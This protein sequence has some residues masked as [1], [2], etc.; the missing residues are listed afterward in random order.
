MS[1]VLIGKGSLAGKGVYACKGF[2]KGEVVIKYNFK[3][4]SEQE[5]KQL[6][7]S[8]KMFAHSHWGQIYLYGAPER[9]VNHSENPNTY[10][11]LKNKCD[12]AIRD[13]AKGE[14]VTTDESKDDIC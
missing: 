1:D 8:E 3:P 2:K 6:S 13:I 4:I 10:P 5:Y 9:Y 7:D 14:M 11:D 12:V